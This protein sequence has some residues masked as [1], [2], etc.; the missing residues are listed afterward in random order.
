MTQPKASV[1]PGTPCGACLG[2]NAI[3]A[4][5]IIV[6]VLITGAPFGVTVAGLKLQV[7]P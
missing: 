4:G 7:V 5:T 1:P 2:A 3:C 6:T